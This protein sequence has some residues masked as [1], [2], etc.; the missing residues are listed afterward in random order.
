MWKKI[1]IPHTVKFKEGAP[2]KEYLQQ[3][4]SSFREPC[5]LVEILTWLKEIIRDN[6]LFD[7][8][9]PAMIVGDASLEE[10]LRSKKVHVNDIRVW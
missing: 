4:V 8:R 1:K 2:L 9:N 10:A 5:T 3:R 7:E 6:L